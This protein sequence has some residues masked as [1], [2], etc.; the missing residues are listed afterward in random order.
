M[1]PYIYGW[2]IFSKCAKTIHFNEEKI[3]FL[4]SWCLIPGQ[5]DIC[6]KKELKKKKAKRNKNLDP[7]LKKKLN[8]T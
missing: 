1:N 2:L 8:G 7:Y 6:I 3:V 5:L 4:K